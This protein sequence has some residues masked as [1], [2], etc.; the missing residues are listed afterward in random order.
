MEYAFMIASGMRTYPCNYAEIS[1]G[2]AATQEWTSAQRDGACRMVARS[3]PEMSVDV[4]ADI[5]WAL[6]PGVKCD[7][8]AIRNP[9]YTRFRPIGSIG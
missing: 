3:H 4:P 9:R 7:P 8:D 2:V 6:I 1:T 5:P